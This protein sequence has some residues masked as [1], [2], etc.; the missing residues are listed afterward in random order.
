MGKWVVAHGKRIEIEELQPPRG[1]SIAFLQTKK[2]QRNLRFA[3]VPLLWW[4]KLGAKPRAS[5]ATYH[6]AIYIL[7]LDWKENVK[8]F[9]GKPFKLP[10]K[11]IG[12]SPRTKWWAL[13]QLERRKLIVV[14]RRPR[15]SPLIQL[16]PLK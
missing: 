1:A 13:A 15:K 3:M 9:S 14:E 4:N 5:A 2:D 10:N 6:V 12:T 7:Y 11:S 16:L 8:P